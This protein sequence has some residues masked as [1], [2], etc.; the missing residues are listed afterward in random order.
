MRLYLITLLFLALTCLG[1]SDSDESLQGWKESDV[2]VVN[3]GSATGTTG[4]VVISGDA[5]PMTATSL[6]TTTDLDMI[7]D[8][9]L[10]LTDGTSYDER[11]GRQRSLAEQ[12]DSPSAE[13]RRDPRDSAPRGS[14]AEQRP[15]R[16]TTQS[17]APRPSTAQQSR[18]QSSETEEEEVQR[19]PTEQPEPS[20]ADRSESEESEELPPV[21]VIPPEPPSDESRDTPPP[22]PDREPD[23]PDDDEES[24]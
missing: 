18:P 2:E 5:A 3:E 7:T 17:P 14:T 10:G 19:R 22:A 24:E 9:Q 1:C 8:E 15:A 11:D 13:A 21:V 16:P 4:Q 12:F 6:D 20:P 23:P